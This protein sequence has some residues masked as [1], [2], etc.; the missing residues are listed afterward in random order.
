MTSHEAIASLL[1]FLAAY[2]IGATPFG[3]FAGRMRGVDIRKH[4][5]GNIGATN[6]FR[7]LGKGIGIPVFILDMLKGYLPVILTE[8][9]LRR[10]GI[11]P[12]WPAI[13]AAVGSVAGHNFTFWLGFKGGKG[14]ATSAGVLLALLPVSLVAAILFWIVLFYTTRYVAV[15]SIGAAVMVPSATI[16]LHFL[17][18]PWLGVPEPPLVGFALVIGFLAVWRHRSNIRRLLNGTEHRFA[19][20]N[21]PAPTAS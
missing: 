13:F 4:G 9:V 21:P 15:A 12:V 11:Q 5:S 2:V 6:V 17:K 20:K 18:I 10:Q 8:L 7:V 3:Y 16:V 1:A 19:K 14:I